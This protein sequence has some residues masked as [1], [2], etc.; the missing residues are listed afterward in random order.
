MSEISKDKSLSIEDKISMGVDGENFKEEDISEN[1]V[2]Y[3][4]IMRKLIVKLM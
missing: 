4:V 3:I 2:E 1:A